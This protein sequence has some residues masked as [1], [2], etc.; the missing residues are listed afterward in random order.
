MSTKFLQLRGLTSSSSWN[1]VRSMANGTQQLHS[2]W[3]RAAPRYFSVAA[4]AS[5]SDQHRDTFSTAA[6]AALVAFSGTGAVVL[7]EKKQKKEKEVH[8]HPT[9]SEV[10]KE[11][12]EKYQESVDIDAMPEYTSE[13]VAAH[14]GQNGVSMWMSYG[15]VVYDVTDFIVNHPGG[16]EKIS[17]AAGTLVESIVSWL[18]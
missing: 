11:D 6:L 13:Q 17:T 16:S 8:P 7:C 9:P 15:G 2:S 18:L 10:A 14:D 12:F 5:A 1:R 3:K 4:A